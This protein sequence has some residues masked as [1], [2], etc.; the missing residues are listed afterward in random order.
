MLWQ[1]FLDSFDSP[2]AHVLLLA[3]GALLGCAMLTHGL[4]DGHTVLIGSGGAL[5]ALLRSSRG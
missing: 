1:R 5:L 3:L 2:G 4:A